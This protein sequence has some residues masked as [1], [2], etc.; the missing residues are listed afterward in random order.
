MAV[1]LVFYYLKIIS[2]LDV[3]LNLTYFYT[4]NVCKYAIFNL[5]K[6]EGLT[7]QHEIHRFFDRE[8]QHF[9]LGQ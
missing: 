5:I 4:I 8:I 1:P 7:K 6:N 9:D 3:F 2:F